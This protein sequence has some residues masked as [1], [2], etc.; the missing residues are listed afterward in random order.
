[1]GDKGYFW[2]IDV[3]NTRAKLAVFEPETGA[4][5]K[6]WHKPK[7]RRAWFR[8][9]FKVYAPQA[10]IFSSVRGRA[11]RLQAWLGAKVPLFLAFGPDT[12]I[13]LVNAYASPQTLGRD[14]LAA[15]LGA[16]QRY[17]GQPSL[18][19]NA[20]T[21]LT[22]D[23]VDEQGVYQGGAISPGLRMRLRAMA[24]FTARLPQLEPWPTWPSDFI[25]R[26]TPSSML[27]GAQWGMVQEIQGF[28]ALYQTLAPNLRVLI[29][30]GDGSLLA[31]ALPCDNR[32]LEPNIV[33]LGLYQILKHHVSLS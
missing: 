8:R 12:P 17:P 24:E 25:G 29:A 33:L 3:G 1:M 19:L 30:G 4:L 14:R 26:D 27:T 15:A 20:G 28:I 21:C 18:V 31:E 10:L 16:W 9:K 32:V 5:L 7:P 6:L 22:Y 11:K 23:Y 2:V 13:P